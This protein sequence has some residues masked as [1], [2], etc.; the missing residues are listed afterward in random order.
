LHRRVK[1]QR[2]AAAGYAW[3]FSAITASPG[4]RTHYDRR[5]ADEDRQAAP[6]LAVII[7]GGRPVNC[8]R[9]GVIGM[10][11]AAASTPPVPAFP[12]A[13]TPP[14]G[15]SS[16]QV[17]ERRSRGL[18]NAGGEH[19][20]RSVAHILRV[21]ILTRFN[22]LL[23]VLL[24]VI[25]AVGQPQDAL[26]GI[27][28]ELR[29]KRTLDRLAV[30]SASRVRV[31]RDGAPRDIAIGELVAGDLVDLRAGDQLAAD[32]VGAGQRELAG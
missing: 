11:D 28:Q 4:A 10:A 19:T 6:G 27:G 8:L 31:I 13:E 21:N 14:A 7:P 22:L 32:G 20:S 16:G 30:L 1:N 29:A 18:T 3:A 15:L 5:K 2:L 23:G 9:D 25:L 24:A 17:A 12:V 26:F